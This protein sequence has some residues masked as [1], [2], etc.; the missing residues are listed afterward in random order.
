[1]CVCEGERVCVREGERVCMRV[2]VLCVCKSILYIGMYVVFCIGMYVEG[3]AHII[4]NYVC[5][6]SV[7]VFC[8]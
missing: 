3:H 2:C 7:K 8:I 4:L 1:M 5:C 6:V